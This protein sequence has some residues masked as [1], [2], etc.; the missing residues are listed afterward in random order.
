VGIVQV[1]VEIWLNE[2]C[3]TRNSRICLQQQ[4][5]YLDKDIALQSKQW[6]RP[7]D[8]IQNEEDW[9]IGRSKRVCRK[10]EENTKGS[11]SSIE[12]DIEKDKKISG[13]EEGK[14]REI[15][16][17]GLSITKHQRLEVENERKM[18]RKA[19]REICRTLQ[20]KKGHIN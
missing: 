2:V 18:N 20:N 5:E 7:Q 17:R 15:P 16:R 4:G 12:K 6:Q 11:L 8:G 9:K 10:N 14:S 1:F 3:D 13:W 19:D